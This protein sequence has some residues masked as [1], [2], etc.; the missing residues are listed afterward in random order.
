MKIKANQIDIEIEDTHPGDTTGRPVVLLIMGL[1]MQLI[2]WPPAM[3]QAIA[4][5]GFRVLRFDNRDIGLSQHLDHL[6]SPSLLWEGLKFRLGWRIRPPYSVQDMAADTVGVLDAL[7][8]AKAHVVGVSMGGMVAQR[9]A[10]LAPSRVVSLCSIMSSSGARGLPE[11]SP[12]VTRVLL[13]RPAGKGVQAAVDHTAR[14]LKAIGSPG[15]PTPD[16]ELR[17]KVAAAAQ[18]SFHPQG[19]LRQMVAIAADSTRAAALAQVRAP[20]LVVHGR[21]DP[22]VPMACGQDTARRI[23]GARFES[24][25]GMGHDLPPGVVERLL[26]LLI[27][28]F[29]ATTAG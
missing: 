13:S 1:G 25:E 11:A 27:P 17:E 5:A 15:F 23:P 29:R 2:A 19:V 12:A 28:H 8:I 26:A 24:I 21:A 18:R 16:A 6:G 10:V 7:Q 14:L 20:T 4:D 9:V 3:V 22:L